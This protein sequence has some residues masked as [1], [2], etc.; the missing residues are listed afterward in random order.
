MSKHQIIEI[1]SFRE[2]QNPAL[3]V[4][5][6]G[7][8]VGTSGAM[9]CRIERGSRRPSVDLAK[10]ISAV[11]GIPLTTLRPDIFEAAE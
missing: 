10:R 6:F 7:E 1:K 2:R 11:T 3:G 8:M 4:R 5:A 9:V